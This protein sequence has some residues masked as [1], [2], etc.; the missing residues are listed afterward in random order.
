[1][2]PKNVLCLAVVTISGTLLSTVFSP[3]FASGSVS[4][5]RQSNVERLDMTVGTRNPYPPGNCGCSCR[6]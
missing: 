3:A 2:K 1:M 4:D 5:F 6:L